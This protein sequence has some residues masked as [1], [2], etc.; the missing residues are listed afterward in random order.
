M[1]VSTAKSLIRSGLNESST[2]KV[3]DAEVLQS[4]NDGQIQVATRG[5]CLEKVIFETTITG[6]HIIPGHGVK[7]TSVEL[8]GLDSYTVFSGSY[9]PS[10]VTWYNTAGVSPTNRG[11]PCILPTNIG[12]L[13]LKG[14]A[15]QRWFNW[16]RYIVIEP[17]ADARYVLKLHYADYPATLTADLDELEVPLEFQQC[18]IDFAISVLSIK[19]RRW[20]EVATFYNK[21]ILG[22]QSAKEVYIKKR[23]DPRAA[24]DIPDAVKEDNG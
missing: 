24:R 17:T 6:Q 16:G 1:I 3:S 7:V 14:T 12:Y 18:V 8:L 5:L 21:Y 20:S 13:P 11:M 19:L 23:P 15:P 22:L 2:A 10:D 9:E 4:I